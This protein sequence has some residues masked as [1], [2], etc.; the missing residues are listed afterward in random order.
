MMKL[1]QAALIFSFGLLLGLSIVFLLPPRATE[2][3]IPE[4][5]LFRFSEVGLLNLTF[6]FFPRLESGFLALFWES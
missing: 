6:D 4:I 3:A 2:Q 1:L 5:G